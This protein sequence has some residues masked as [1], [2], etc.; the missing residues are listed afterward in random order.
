M[1][2]RGVPLTNA[3]REAIRSAFPV[4]LQLSFKMKVPSQTVYRLMKDGQPITIDT[5]YKLSQAI[6]MDFEVF[7]SLK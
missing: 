7:K 1:P 2:T 6:G 4:M 5:M 3:Q